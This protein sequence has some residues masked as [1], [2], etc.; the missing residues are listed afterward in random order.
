MTTAVRRCGM[1]G[2]ISTIRNQKLARRRE[3]GWQHYMSPPPFVEA[4]AMLKPGIVSAGT[5]S[6]MRKT[7]TEGNATT[8]R[9]MEGRDRGEAKHAA[10]TLL[11]LL[12]VLAIV[13]VVMDYFWVQFKMHV[14]RPSA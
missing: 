12:V 8:Q 5:S 2:D 9:S 10:F 7:T 13:P 3:T 11:E 1:P 14:L 6:R 4:L